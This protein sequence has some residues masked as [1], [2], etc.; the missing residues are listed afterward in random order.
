MKV[1]VMFSV[2]P[3]GTGV[4]LSEYIAACERVLAET[5]L[6]T[7]LHAHGTNVSGEWDEVF[8][9]IRRCVEAV[10]EMGAPRI[11]TF[12]KLGTRTDRTPDMDAM[13][14]SVQSKL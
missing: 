12:I 11:S 1:T 4:S 5:G 8:G 3:I 10:H 7:Q 6:E 13:V 2:I 14:R 9:A